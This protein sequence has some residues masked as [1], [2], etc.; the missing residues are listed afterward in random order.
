[1]KLFTVVL[2]WLLGSKCGVCQTIQ[3]DSPKE[4]MARARNLI[5]VASGCP[6][7][8]AVPKYEEPLALLD[9]AYQLS[10][11][12][13]ALKTHIER[14]RSICYDGQA[15]Y[16]EKR[17]ALI[18]WANLESKGD[19]EKAARLMITE[20]EAYVARNEVSEA[21]ALYRLTAFRY[22]ATEAGQEALF[23]VTRILEQEE[24]KCGYL[25]N[26]VPLYENMLA[27][28]PRGRLAGKATV[29][30]SS[31]YL[32]LKDRDKAVELLA[33]YVQDNPGTDD[34]S[35]ALSSLAD[36]YWNSGKNEEA[37][38]LV[39]GW[40][41]SHP[42]SKLSSAMLWKLAG[43]YEAMGDLAKTKE[44]LETYRRMYPKG[45]E[46]AA[47]DFLLSAISAKQPANLRGN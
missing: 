20:A 19:D 46:S 7:A 12:D 44:V 23:N 32:S 17:E 24:R 1:M 34:A 22:P 26:I 13:A 21:I 39:S 45:R 35:E 5:E 40:V 3:E 30:L 27:K 6:K 25:T 14:L 33:T 11:K 31:V 42:G 36:I 29:A 10:S 2:I 9:R 28:Y 4:L 16:W 38:S 37:I 43:L 47:V 18:R 15:E 41:Q 8:K